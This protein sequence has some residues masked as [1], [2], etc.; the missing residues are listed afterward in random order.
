MAK[1]QDLFGINVNETSLWEADRTCF[2]VFE[3][4]LVLL[5]GHLML[6]YSK[7]STSEHLSKVKKNS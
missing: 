6:A 5:D 2:P 1:V 3:L 7:T 4:G